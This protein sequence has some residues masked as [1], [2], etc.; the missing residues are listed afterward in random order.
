M[1]FADRRYMVSWPWRESNPDLPQNYISACSWK[2]EI[3]SN[4][5][6]EDP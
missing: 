6:S 3:D 4:E 1:I 2:T 5:I